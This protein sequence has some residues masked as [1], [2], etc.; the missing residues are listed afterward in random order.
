MYQYREG[1]IIIYNDREA[2]IHM[3]I[4]MCTFLIWLG[5]AIKSNKFVLFSVYS[6]INVIPLVF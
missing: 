2:E 1:A 3:F 4:K 5:N 6:Y